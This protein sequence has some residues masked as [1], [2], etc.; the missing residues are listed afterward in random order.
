[1]SKCVRSFRLFLVSS[2]AI[3]SASLS[4]LTA[5]MVIS[6]RFPIGVGTR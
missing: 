3:R 5:R 6:S 1:M 2:A 4:T